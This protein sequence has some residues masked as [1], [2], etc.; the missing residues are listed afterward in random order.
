L[1]LLY[2]EYFWNFFKLF[3][4]RQRFFIKSCR[5]WS[6]ATWNEKLYKMC[7][8]ISIAGE[9]MG[10][11]LTNRHKSLF[12]NML[13]HPTPSPSPSRGGELVTTPI[14]VRLTRSKLNN[15]ITLSGKSLG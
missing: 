1:T 5:H 3:V 10:V 15:L 14:M 13:Q 2:A 12:N 6:R 7:I 4:K 11:G 9:G 8:K